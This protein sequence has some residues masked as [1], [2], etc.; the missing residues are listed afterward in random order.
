MEFLVEV[1]KEGGGSGDMRLG[2][3]SADADGKSSKGA[4]HRLKLKL[5]VRDTEPGDQATVSD[6]RCS[7]VTDHAHPRLVAVRTG[8]LDARGAG[9]SARG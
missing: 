9:S 5:G 2:L 4:S 7:V 6:R 1:T 8:T 3:V